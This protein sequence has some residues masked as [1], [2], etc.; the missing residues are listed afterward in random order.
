MHFHCK[1]TCAYIPWLIWIALAHIQLGQDL[2]STV[3]D[4]D[5]FPRYVLIGFQMETVVVLFIPDAVIMY[6]IDDIDS[7]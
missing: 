1:T 6:S 4:F 7:M 5:E 3:G 2:D